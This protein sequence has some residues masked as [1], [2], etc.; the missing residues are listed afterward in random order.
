L[1]PAFPL[2]LLV[3][4]L[5]YLSRQDLPTM[6]LLVQYVSPLGLVSALLITLAWV[7]PVIVLTGRALG[8]LLLVSAHSEPEKARSW[9]VRASQRIPGWV[10]LLAMLLAALTWQM[11]FLPA[12][13]MTAVSIAG[14]TV[15]SRYGGRPRLVR[16]VCIVLPLVVA[17]AA[18]VWLVEAIVD[19]FRQ[20]EPVTALLLLVPPALMPW[21]TG[22]V[23]ARAARL[24]THWPAAGAALLSP[25]LIGAI[26][27]QAP[28]LPTVALEVD[29][30]R[31]A[32]TPPQI[33]RGHVITVDDQAMTLLDGAGSVLFVPNEQVLSRTLC[34][35]AELAPASVVAVHGWPVE[36]TALEWIAP[37]RRAVPSDPRCLGRPLSG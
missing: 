6:L 33:I 23:P 9:L 24:V 32:A 35:D 1:L 11:R 28:I 18:Y 31:Q 17:T 2:V 25:F 15:R 30:D 21:L 4:R 3:L 37:A 26:F 10:V 19:S 5:W 13:L 12:L 22:P 27:V 29:T 20:G 7:L 14:L 8:T 16:A 34:P 36:Q